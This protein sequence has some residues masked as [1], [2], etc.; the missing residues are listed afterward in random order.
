MFFQ[1]CEWPLWSLSIFLL[2]RVFNKLF[3]SFIDTEVGEMDEPFSNI[4]GFYIVLVCSKSSQ[5]L[6]EHI[7]SQRVVASHYDIDSEV[8]FEVIDQM[9]VRNVLWN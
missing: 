7:N 9:R 4:F 6:F 2:F 1:G 8:V 5:S 3:W